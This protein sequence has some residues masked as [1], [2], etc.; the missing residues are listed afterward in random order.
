MKNLFLKVSQINGETV[1]LP[2]QVI[3]VKN[4]MVVVS[5]FLLDHPIPLLFEVKHNQINTL[6]DFTKVNPYEIWFFYLDKDEVSF[7]KSFSL[8]NSD[9]P[10]QIQTQAKYIAI[11]PCNYKDLKQKQI[12]ASSKL[13]NFKTNNSYLPDTQP[14]KKEIEDWILRLFQLSNDELINAFNRETTIK[15]WGQ[16]RSHYLRAL[17]CEIQ[18]RTFKSDILFEYNKN[19]SVNSFLLKNAV[20]INNGFLEFKNT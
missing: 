6:F 19:G 13:V 10:F 7:G 9:I 5:D 11:V 8:G 12:D 15:S 3:E 1:D 16:A 4:A 18:N 17:Q 20:Q 14:Y 2:C